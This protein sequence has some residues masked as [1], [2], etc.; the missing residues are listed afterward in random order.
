MIKL[1]ELQAARRGMTPLKTAIMMSIGCVAAFDAGEYDTCRL[2][3][4]RRDALL[5]R[6]DHFDSLTFSAWANE[7]LTDAQVDA[8]LSTDEAS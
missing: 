3:R 7:Q 2:L 1:S 5:E 8:I 6:L 4:C